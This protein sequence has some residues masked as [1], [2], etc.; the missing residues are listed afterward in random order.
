MTRVVPRSLIGPVVSQIGCWIVAPRS[1]A[2]AG[3]ASRKGPDLLLATKI[4]GDYLIPWPGANGGHHDDCSVHHHRRR[5]RAHHH[6]RGSHSGVSLPAAPAQL[7]HDDGGKI[8]DSPDDCKWCPSWRSDA[9]GSAP[10]PEAT[11]SQV[12][13]LV[14]QRNETRKGH[15]IYR[16][17]QVCG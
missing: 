6:G 5:R 15:A 17:H 14:R 3:S 9:S 13:H 1:S 10:P 4:H 8:G 2:H 7:V 11:R 16:T 12:C